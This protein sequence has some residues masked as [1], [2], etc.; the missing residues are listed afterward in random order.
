MYFL[1]RL[2][3]DKRSSFI[4]LFFFIVVLLDIVMLHRSFGGYEPNHSTFLSGNSEG[5]Y[6]QMLLLWLL[7]IYLIFGTSSWQLS[8]FNSGNVLSVISR[9]D[10]KYYWRIYN[11]VNFIYGFSL[12]FI[13]TLTNYA[14]VSIAFRKVEIVPFLV[15]K[16]VAINDFQTFLHSSIY[17]ELSHPELSNLFHIVIASLIV[18]C[19]CVII[20]TINIF[21]KSFYYTIFIVIS[22]WYL[23]ISLTPSIMVA[24]Q[25][26]TEYP[27]SL[28]LMYLVFSVFLL[29]ISLL[30]Q[31]KWWKE[32]DFI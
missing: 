18:G 15:E 10:R 21:T 26:F 31:R 1:R 24:F 23:L 16:S 5:H 2:F 28:K 8:D 3:K 12:I 22:I 9:A 6:A 30:I 19:M 17:W 14:V 27:I 25:P 29:V 13:S 11:Q 4:F 32:N 7:P 20:S